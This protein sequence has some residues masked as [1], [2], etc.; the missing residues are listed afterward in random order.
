[1]R[2]AEILAKRV[3]RIGRAF[4]L[5]PRGRRR[6][7]DDAPPLAAPP[8]T[9]VEGDDD[10]KR[11]LTGIVI[12][13]FAL[14][15]GATAATLS[16]TLVGDEA[17]LTGLTVAMI[18][19]VSRLHGQDW[20]VGEGLAL[21]GSMA[22]YYLAGRGAVFLVKWVPLVGNAANAVTSVVVAETLGWA[23]YLLVR[24]RRKPG[25]LGKGEARAVY[26]RAR[27]LR[28]EM[29][30]ESKRLVEAMSPE[31]KAEYERMIRR[32]KI[33]DLPPHERERALD[34]LDRLVAKYER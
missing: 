29:D 4:R 24:E 23:A 2:P 32:L 14:A 7:N 17:A 1:M 15:H 30:E 22:G 31:D 10:H 3:E 16:Q 25:D 21:I 33:R 19:S 18:M 5:L 34:A 6:G 8:R 9:A 13:G 26:R 20:S 12:H 28:R 27:E 11:R